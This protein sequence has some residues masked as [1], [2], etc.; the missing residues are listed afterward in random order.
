VGRDRAKNAT[1]RMPPRESNPRT[2]AERDGRRRGSHQLPPGRHGLP[3]SYV[4]ANQRERILT[5]VVDAVSFKGYPAMS[6]DD[7]ITAAGVSRRTFYDTFTDKEDAFLA[8]FDRGRDQL[9][10]RV[11]AAYD[12]SESFPASVVAWLRALLEFVSAEPG[13]AELCIVEVLAAGPPAI[14]RRNAVMRSLAELVDRSAR[15]WVQ[16]PLP[17]PLTAETLIGGIFEVVY[18]RVLE[19]ETAG[20]PALLADLAYSVM[21]PY[22]GHE[23]AA[24]ELH[25]RAAV[26]S[27]TQACAGNLR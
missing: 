2:P 25:G 7:I 21:L 6:V 5:A 4:T 8:A 27:T 26:A 14:E 11:A 13:Y 9:L 22:L 15:Q 1:K 3:R 24:R 23:R 16:G 19:G 12:T 17:P 20:V 18:S 10:G